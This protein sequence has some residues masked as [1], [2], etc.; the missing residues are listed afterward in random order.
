MDTTTAAIMSTDLFG[1]PPTRPTYPAGDV[2]CAV[3]GA[4]MT[5]TDYAAHTHPEPAPGL[6]A[7]LV[8]SYDHVPASA[9]PDPNSP[10]GH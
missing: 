1:V 4:Q 9:L 5:F 7:A 6:Y 3:C 10:E 2:R 8:A